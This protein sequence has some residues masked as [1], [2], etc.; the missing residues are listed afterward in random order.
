ME[1]M[2][3]ITI[4]KGGWAFCLHGGDGEHEWGAIEP[5]PVDTLRF[6]R[7]MAPASSEA[8]ALAE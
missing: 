6:R 1:Y 2:P 7:G 3:A 5:A 8:M 4:N